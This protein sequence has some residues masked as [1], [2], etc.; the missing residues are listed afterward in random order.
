MTHPGED[1][2]V[3]YHYG[4][5][6]ETSAIAGHLRDCQACANAYDRLRLVLAAVSEADAPEPAADYGARLFER[7]RPRLAA[8]AVDAAVTDA[9]ERRVARVLPFAR[10]LRPLLA[11]AAT[12]VVA[13]M[14]GRYTRE[15]EVVTVPGPVRERVLLIAVGDHLDRSQMVLAELVHAGGNGEVDIRSERDWAQDLV[16]ANRLYRQAAVRAGERGVASV[17]DDLERVLVEIATSPDSVSSARLA[18][19]SERIES[20][21]ILFKLRVLGAQVRDRERAMVR[22]ASRS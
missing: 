16:S 18:E 13:F 6:P 21:G 19:L 8:Q 5:T 1:D 22:A 7:L 15:P 20:Q 9:A 14:L 17:L 2:L 11:L 10:R 3:L 4:E 12:V